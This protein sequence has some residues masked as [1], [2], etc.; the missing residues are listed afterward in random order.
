MVRGK[1]RMGAYFGR[2][3]ANKLR[4]IGGYYDLW[5]GKDIADNEWHTIEVIRNIRETI[6]F[7][8]REKGKLKKEIFMKSPPT[9]NRLSVDLVTFG[10]YWSFAPNEITEE[11]SQARKGIVSVKQCLVSIGQWKMGQLTVPSIS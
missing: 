4:P 6:M 8:D 1:A 9:Y 7:V 3:P 5:Q 10:G 2:G 11:N